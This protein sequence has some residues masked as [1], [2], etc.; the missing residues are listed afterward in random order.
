MNFDFA[1]E[2][3]KDIKRLAKK[4]RSIPSDIEAVK[5]YIVPLYVDLPGETS[6]EQYLHDFFATNRATILEQGDGYEVVKMRLDCAMLGNDK[7]TRLIFV[8]V[9]EKELVRFIELYAKNTNE[10]E[11]AKRIKR[12]LS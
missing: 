11:D 5:Q 1:P 9:I 8:A 6:V 10:R 2:C 3:T 12:Y 4:W 7:K